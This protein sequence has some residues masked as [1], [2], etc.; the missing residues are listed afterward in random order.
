MM[1][2]VI[3]N[4]TKNGNI[5]WLSDNSFTTVWQLLDKL[6]YNSMTTA[7]RLPD[8]YLMTSRQLWQ[9]KNISWVKNRSSVITP[10]SSSKNLTTISIELEFLWDFV[11]L[12]LKT[13]SL[14]HE[15]LFI[16]VVKDISSQ[17]FNKFFSASDIMEAVR[18]CLCF[19]I[20]ECMVAWFKLYCCKI[21]G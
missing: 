20:Y 1:I 18:G 5:W 6:P 3:A 17:V 9:L 15:K 2:I 7:W 14:Y 8:I 12:S 4:L 11:H 19:Y 16:Q 21:N 10:K 13:C